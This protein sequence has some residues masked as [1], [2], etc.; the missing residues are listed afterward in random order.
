MELR[1]QTFFHFHT[2]NTESCFVLKIAYGR[3]K[4]LVLSPNKLTDDHLTLKFLDI[5][6]ASKIETR[7]SRGLLLSCTQ[8][9]SS[10]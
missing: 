5:S 3:E 4:T 1:S 9:N 2:N 8:V 7:K 6:E 10:S